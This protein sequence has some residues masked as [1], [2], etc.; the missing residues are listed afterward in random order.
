MI[1]MIAREIVLVMVDEAFVGDV[2]EVLIFSFFPLLQRLRSK[3][4]GLSVCYRGGRS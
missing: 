2:E 4:L 3:L 1:M